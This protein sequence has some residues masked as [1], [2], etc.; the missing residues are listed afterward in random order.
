M[1]LEKVINKKNKNDNENTQLYYGKIRKNF[2]I[3]VKKTEIQKYIL[4]V[5]QANIQHGADGAFF[6]YLKKEKKLNFI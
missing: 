2:F 5:E 4:S 3:W 1:L 6:V